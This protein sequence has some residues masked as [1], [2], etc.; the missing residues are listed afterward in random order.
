[1]PRERPTIP[2]RLGDYELIRRIGEGGMGYVYL[3]RQKSKNRKVALKLLPSRPGLQARDIERFMR[4]AQSAAK[5]RHPRIVRIHDV[6]TVDGIHLY[7]MDFIPGHDLGTEIHLLKQER[8]R[9][10]LD[11][12]HLL[13]RVRSQDYF[14]T[15]VRIL[16]EVAE[17]LHHAHEAGIVHRDVK[18]QN[19][20]ID[21]KLEAFIV[22]FGLARDDTLSG[23]TL[24]GDLVGSPAYMSP[25]QVMGRR[26][27]IDHR[28][29]VY[30][31]GVVLYEL[32][33]LRRPFEGRTS[34]E[35]LNAVLE[36]E[37][38]PVHKLNPRV[39][40]DL[41]TICLKAMARQPEHRYASAHEFAIDCRHFLALE[42]IEARP[43]T[44]W[45]RITGF[46]RRHRVESLVT[47]A[48][49]IA[50][51]AV[52][53]WATQ[54]V[55]RSNLDDRVERLRDIV[56]D[57]SIFRDKSADRLELLVELHRSLNADRERLSPEQ[58]E[59]LDRATRRMQ[60]VVDD[61]T[62][63]GLTIIDRVSQGAE[64][65]SIEEL[66]A[67]ALSK[68][69]TARR[70]GAVESLDLS[71]NVTTLVRPVVV[72]ESVDAFG[73]DRPA[74]LYAR[75]ADPATG[76]WGPSK[77]IGKLPITER[78]DA[79]LYRF[80]IVFDAGGYR[81]YTRQLAPL[82]TMQLRAIARSDEAAIKKGM[83]EFAR[84]ET[85]CVDHW[86]CV[87][88]GRAVTVEP[89]LLD[90]CEVSNADYK[91]FCESTG[92]P[93]PHYFARAIDFDDIAELPVTFVPYDH[94][95]AYAEWCGK[96]LPTH[97]ELARATFGTSDSPRA[98]AWG[99]ADPKLIGANIASTPEW[100]L[101]GG[102]TIAQFQ[103]A[104]RPVRSCEGARSP[105][106]VYHLSGNVREV[107]ENPGTAFNSASDELTAV[108]VRA[109]A[110]GIDP[111][112]VLILGEGFDTPLR[113]DMPFPHDS[114]ERDPMTFARGDLGFRCAKSLNPRGP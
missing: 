98:W 10:T 40:F 93:M 35:I 77:E 37:P 20:L 111:S 91:R 54:R 74:M 19:I 82:R 68:L 16:A 76:D 96:R 4:E 44:R 97:S 75:V 78:F 46:F 30:S 105:E 55:R 65:G 60:S 8:D 92:T 28:T 15:I 69:D 36:K 12:P 42:A 90:A 38:P 95:L 49:I 100:F 23:I 2:D 29:D 80:T 103:E 85:R 21:A 39:P 34:R 18:P 25:E 107:T 72:A 17:A 24:S 3:A 88:N 53:F 84:S 106:G 51:F 94:M 1:M 64:S 33:A 27:H 56:A 32:L 104:L 61:L 5:L 86:Y 110:S 43:P 87:F 108:T 102:A 83:V 109:M 31:L 59:L 50:L 45:R 57:Q 52:A 48:A 63:D 7:A 66:L 47:L 99:D 9:V 73:N 26:V 67:N 70:Y 113:D 22:D 6:A 14:P 79:G 13:P 71:P 101:R 114:V 41:S 81:E 58:L 112:T 89:F 62:H 11:E